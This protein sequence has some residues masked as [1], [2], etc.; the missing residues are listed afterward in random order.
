MDSLRAALAENDRLSRQSREHDASITRA[1]EEEL[2]RIDA[3][4]MGMP[5]GQVARDSARAYE[6]RRLVE[7]RARLL[8]LVS[9]R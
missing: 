6:Y 8:R 9:A 5:A 4:L 3:R 1:A 7:D 2:S